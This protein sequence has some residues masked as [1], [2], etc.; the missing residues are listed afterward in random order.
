MSKLFKVFLCVLLCSAL[1]PLVTRFVITRERVLL[2]NDIEDDNLELR[3]TY[4]KHHLII[5]GVSVFAEVRSKNGLLLEKYLVSTEDLIGDVR[6]KYK[7]IR[8]D[9]SENLV[10]AELSSGEKVKI[11]MLN[12]GRIK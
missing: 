5:D 8:W 11:K 9:S 4:K 3:I 12:P 6:R 1:I 7:V 2:I 10:V